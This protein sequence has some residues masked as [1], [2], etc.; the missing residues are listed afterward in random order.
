MLKLGFLV[1]FGVTRKRFLAILLIVLNAFTW[2]LV[3]FEVLTHMLE[4]VNINPEEIVII[5]TIHFGAISCAAL[6]GATVSDRLISRNNLLALWMSL[7]VVSSFVPAVIGTASSTSIAVFS[8]LLGVAFGLGMPSCMGYFADFTAIEKRGR[9]GGVIY[10]AICVG[11]FLLWTTLIPLTRLVEQLVILA[12][13]RGFGLATFL[14]LKSEKKYEK[15]KKSPSY[16]A[17]L[18]K[19]PLLFYLIPWIMFCLIDSLT[20]PIFPPDIVRLS[21]IIGSIIT[22]LFALVGGLFSDSLGRKPVVITGFVLL[23]IGY[24]ILGLFPE[25]SIAFYLFSGLDGIAWGMFSAVFLMTLWGDLAEGVIPEKYYAIGGLPYLL[26]SFLTLLGAP[27]ISALFSPYTTF[28][29]A[30]FFLFL[31]VFPILFAPETLP[32]K[33]MKERELKKYIEKAKNIKEKYD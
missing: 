2:Y 30:S 5:W 18:G 7:G 9:S 33:K 26:S 16:V 8:F 25:H 15:R 1:N 4:A 24:A 19:K 32:E 29:L 21:M 3:A 11:A 28:S 10:F 13:W 31:A 12:I 20:R 14:I 6:I 17:I 27:Y 22:G 23:G